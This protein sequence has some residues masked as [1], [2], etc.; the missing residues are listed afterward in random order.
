MKYRA[1]LADPPWSY[2]DKL[3]MDPLVARGSESMYEKIERLIDG[4]YL[5]LLLDNTVRAG[6]RGERN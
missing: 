2:N 5:E 6:P 3:R 4:P 1:V